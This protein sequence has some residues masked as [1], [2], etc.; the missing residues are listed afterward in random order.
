MPIPA[1]FPPEALVDDRQTLMLEPL[2]RLFTAG[3]VVVT[4]NVTQDCGQSASGK[5]LEG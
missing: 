3:V 1:V 4:G 2:D 5:A